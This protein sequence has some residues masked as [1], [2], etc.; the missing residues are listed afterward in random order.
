MCLENNASIAYIQSDVKVDERDPMGLFLSGHDFKTSMFD[1]HKINV[2]QA[3]LHDPPE[4]MKLFELKET[5]FL[6][7]TL[8]QT[9]TLFRL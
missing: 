1:L 3:Y 4:M 7:L 9:Y 6:F 2:Q 8:L 5:D